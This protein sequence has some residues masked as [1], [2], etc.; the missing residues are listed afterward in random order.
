M[1]PFQNIDRSVVQLALNQIGDA[2]L[3]H[4]NVKLLLFCKYLLLLYMHAYIHDDDDTLHNN[5]NLVDQIRR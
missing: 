4:G 2:C 5:L 1:I 3:R